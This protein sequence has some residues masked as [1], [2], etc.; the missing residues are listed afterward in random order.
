MFDVLIYL[1]ENFWTREAC[2]DHKQL[3]RKLSAVGFEQDDIQDALSWLDGLNAQVQALS[4]QVGQHTGM[5][6]YIE[7][8]VERLGED[9]LSFLRFLESAGVLNPVQREL[10]L[11]RVMA[12]EDRPISL[13]DFKIL[14]LMVFWSFDQELD[15]LILDELFVHPEDRV[16]H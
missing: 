15:A 16:I 11:D 5:R 1:Y 2:A 13:E 12:V 4:T 9:G 3:A 14:V 6:H 10:V 8:E 7:A